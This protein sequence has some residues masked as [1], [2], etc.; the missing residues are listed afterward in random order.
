MENRFQGA[1]VSFI[2]NLSGATTAEIQEY[3]AEIRDDRKCHEGIEEKRNTYGR[4]RE[5]TWYY[6]IGTTLGTILYIF[7]RKQRPDS[8]IETGGASGV[9]SSQ[10]LCALEAKQ[11]GRL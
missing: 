6:G 5:S 11:R 10:L 4:R 1:A 3:A 2:T 8:I 9:S 7:C